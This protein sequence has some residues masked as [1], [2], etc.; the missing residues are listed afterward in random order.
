MKEAVIRKCIF[1]GA[2]L[3]IVLIGL[4][5]SLIAIMDHFDFRNDEKNADHMTEIIV[6]NEH[7]LYDDFDAYDLI[8]L[9]KMY[10][11][12]TED[13]ATRSKNS[14]FFYDK[15]QQ[16]VVVLK[17]EDLEVDPDQLLLREG[18]HVLIRS[19]GIEYLFGADLILLTYQGSVVTEV[20][21]FIN[22]MARQGKAIR[23]AHEEQMDRLSR[24]PTHFIS[25]TYGQGLDQTLI[26]QLKAVLEFYAPNRTLFVNDEQWATSTSRAE[27]VH[28]VVVDRGIGR[29]PAFELDIEGSISIDSFRIPKNLDTFKEG[30]L[31]EHVF[32]IEVIVLKL[33]GSVLVEPGSMPSDVLVID[34]VTY[35]HKGVANYSDYVKIDYREEQARYDFS[36]LPIQNEITSY[37]VEQTSGYTTILLFTDNDLVGFASNVHVMSYYISSKHDLPSILYHCTKTYDLDIDIGDY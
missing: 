37:M 34:E 33:D 13:Y 5:P 1:I 27:D 20:I 16:R 30:A 15:A 28:T 7:L 2:F 19:S 29:L 10:G 24:Y 36:R 11:I 9:L 6:Q 22:G 12:S 26:E 25:R 8:G 35:K 17:Y 31:P 18:N 3:L 14:G 32:D 4:I 23:S 21:D